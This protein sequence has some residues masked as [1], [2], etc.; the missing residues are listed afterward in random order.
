MYDNNESGV[1]YIVVR[2]DL[3]SMGA[4]KCM[5]QVA[6]AA[7][8]FTHHL[9][10]TIL[11]FDNFTYQSVKRWKDQTTQ[12]FGTTIVLETNG[13]TDMLRSIVKRA[14]SENFIADVVVDPT[15][16]VN[17]GNKTHLVTLVTAAYVFVPTKKVETSFL[18][19]FSLARYNWDMSINYSG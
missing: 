1:L 7:N 14:E 13:G 18:K 9:D 15:Y 19:E 5:A 6:H 16:P 12:G 11:D 4:G 8:A 10:T 17:D 2:T 3:T